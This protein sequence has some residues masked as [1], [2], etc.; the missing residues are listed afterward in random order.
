VTAT[1]ES[2]RDSVFETLD[3]DVA[4][5]W[6][7]K[8]L[9]WAGKLDEEQMEHIA[10]RLQLQA[11]MRQAEQLESLVGELVEARDSFRL[12]AEDAVGRE[13]TLEAELEEA[14]TRI[15]A[16][17]AEVAALREADTCDVEPVQ[18]SHQ[19]PRRDW[20]G[21]ECPVPGEVRV[22]IWLRDG[23]TDDGDGRPPE[24]REYY[25]S[26]NGGDADIVAYRIAPDHEQ[27]PEG[28][29][30][31]REYLRTHEPDGTPRVAPGGEE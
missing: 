8:A 9:A 19:Y 25:W 5:E 13:S 4:V 16:L 28:L 17:E 29:A 14:C 12:A 30:A 24:A 27:T 20:G 11:T 22:Y 7:R 15:A 3:L 31:L 1:I 10:T 6:K 23:W 18:P 2:I 26:D 21:G